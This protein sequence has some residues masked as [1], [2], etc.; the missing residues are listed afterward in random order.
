MLRKFIIDVHFYYVD[1]MSAYLLS[2]KTT[3]ASSL[4]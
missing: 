2:L 1:S 4:L 3:K